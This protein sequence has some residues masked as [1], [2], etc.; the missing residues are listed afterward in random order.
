MSKFQTDKTRKEW[1][2]NKSRSYVL[3]RGQAFNLLRGRTVL[4]YWGEK[5]GDRRFGLQKGENIVCG[6][7]WTY[8]LA[9]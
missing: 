4:V 8:C 6:I 1:K 7:I 5:V 2:V 9:Q 3:I